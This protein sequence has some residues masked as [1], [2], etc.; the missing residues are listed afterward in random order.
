[1]SVVNVP[2][3]WDY[4]QLGKAVV[5]QWYVKEGDDIKEGDPLCQIMAAKV[6]VEIPSPA[7]GKVNKIIAQLN[8]EIAPGDPL[9]DIG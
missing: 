9:A 3:M 7:S 5:T 1:M 2:S 8:S 6:T 4:E